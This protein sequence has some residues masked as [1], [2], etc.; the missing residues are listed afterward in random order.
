[1]AIVQRSESYF[2][3]SG[4]HA[5]MNAVHRVALLPDSN[6]STAASYVIVETGRE[7]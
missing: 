2:K 4:Q 3:N 1:M 7:L 5:R 6:V